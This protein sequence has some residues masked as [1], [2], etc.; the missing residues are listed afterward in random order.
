MPKGE[1][2]ARR[3]SPAPGSRPRSAG[4]GRGSRGS[5]STSSRPVS[6]KG[7]PRDSVSSLH[8][9][10]CCCRIKNYGWLQVQVRSELQLLQLQPSTE[11]TRLRLQENWLQACREFWQGNNQISHERIKNQTFFKSICIQSVDYIT[12][13]ADCFFFISELHGDQ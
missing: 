4:A 3:P 7:S 9:L 2:T 11:P 13:G 10:L 12:K 8:W 6:S 1:M 5:T